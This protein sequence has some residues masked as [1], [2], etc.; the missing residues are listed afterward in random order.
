MLYQSKNKR[1]R[2]EIGTDGAVKVKSGDWLSKYSA[3]IYNN[4]YTINVFYRK[5]RTGNLER[6]ANPNLIIAGEVLY[7][8]PTVKK[9]REITFT[10]PLEIVGVVIPKLSDAE[11]KR[12]TVEHLKKEF[13]LRGNHLPVLST[14]IEIVGYA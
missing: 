4:Y 9:V 12:I 2:V 10:K 5:N 11:K 14:A 13:N 1:Y 7:H 3:A 8:L 6:L